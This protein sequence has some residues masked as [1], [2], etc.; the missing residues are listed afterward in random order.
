MQKEGF[1]APQSPFAPSPAPFFPPA[2]NTSSLQGGGLP[3]Q[4][5]QMLGKMG[6]GGNGQMGQLMQMMNLMQLF[7][8][9]NRRN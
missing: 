7:G 4:L 2:Q 8:N 6:G 3:P 1:S 9:M 5:M